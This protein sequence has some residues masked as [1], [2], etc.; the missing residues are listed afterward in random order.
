MKLRSFYFAMPALLA[1]AIFAAA[2]NA[3]DSET[4][5]SA[6]SSDKVQTLQKVIV[7][8]LQKNTEYL[9]ENIIDLISRETFTYEGINTLRQKTISD[10]LIIPDRVKANEHTGCN[11][12]DVKDSL[13]L[14]G[15]V[16]EER[17]VL[18]NAANHNRNYF[19]HKMA[20][21]SGVGALLILFDKKYEDCFDY[22]LAGIGKTRER[23]VYSLEITQVKGDD[24][25]T[26]PV[27]TNEGLPI[28]N[29]VPI[30]FNS[31]AW[32]DAETLEIVRLDRK[33][34]RRN[35]EFMSKITE[36]DV[37]TI[38]H[39]YDQI[40]IKDH[41]LTLP[42][43]KTVKWFQPEARNKN[44]LDFILF[45]KKKEEFILTEVFNFTYSDYRAFEVDTKITFAA[46]EE[47]P[48]NEEKT[49]EAIE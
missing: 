36:W 41:F 3:Q 11:F 42:V 35:I 14:T 47:P 33:P 15:F 31:V 48:D 32:I 20:A 25:V 37:S 34:Y 24:V 44:L 29:I 7:Q 12:I 30:K 22:K 27:K 18:S 45:R 2:G 39:E 28:L 8:R 4:A 6:I 16:K 5:V 38:Q 49:P 1:F 9:K 40:K 43:A 26:V 46:P 23:D 10:F 21:G 19:E 17:R 13:H